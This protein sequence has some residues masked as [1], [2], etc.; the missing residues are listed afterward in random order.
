LEGDALIVLDTHALVWA[1]ADERKLGK[2]ARALIE[3]Q[4]HAGSVA[5]CAISFW[6]AAVL[7]QRG[8]LRL[9]GSPE[10][11]RAELLAAGLMELALDGEAAVRAAGFGGLSDDP[12]DRFIVASALVHGAALVTADES[13]LA[14]P[15]ALRRVDAR[16]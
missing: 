4:W 1:A 14:W 13:L 6:E 10:D 5:V 12:A 11:W 16:R 7:Q 2:K 8:R 15:H 3:R 9:P